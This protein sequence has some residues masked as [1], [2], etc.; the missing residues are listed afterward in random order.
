[1][2]QHLHCCLRCSPLPSSLA[3]A[4][5][6]TPVS[7]S[8]FGDGAAAGLQ[9]GEP[10][11]LLSTPSASPA[12]SNAGGLMAQAAQQWLSTA[13]AVAALRSVS[14]HC[15]ASQRCS[16][17]AAAGPPTCR[18]IMP[19][20][21]GACQAHPCLTMPAPAACRRRHHAQA[22][23]W[24][25]AGRLRLRPPAPGLQGQGEWVGDFFE[26]YQGADMVRKGELA[27]LA[28]PHVLAGMC[29]SWTP[30]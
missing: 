22:P 2:P 28:G 23:G 10:V 9:L 17:A 21:G 11:L 16:P 30:A 26:R 3:P 29:R 14:A 20:V 19:A 7:S 18:P 24:H 25:H 27:A 6:G 15:R 13:G 1:M 4:A 5:A 12:A 8:Y